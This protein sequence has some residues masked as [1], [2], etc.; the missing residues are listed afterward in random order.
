MN[1]THTLT[2]GAVRA[3]AAWAAVQDR[4]RLRP[5]PGLPP[6]RALGLLLDGAEARSRHGD[7]YGGRRRGLN[8]IWTRLSSSV[9]SCVL[10]CL[11]TVTRSC[12]QVFVAVGL[13]CKVLA[14]RAGPGAGARTPDHETRLSTRVSREVMCLCE[15]CA[16]QRHAHGSVQPVHRSHRAREPRPSRERAPPSPTASTQSS[17]SVCCPD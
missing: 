15:L 11:R 4:R 3:R 8:K 1:G 17:H 2:R 6:L 14:R 5:R 13:Y 7:R 9:Q 10:C 12:I 16:L